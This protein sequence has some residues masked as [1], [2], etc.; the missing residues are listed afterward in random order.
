MHKKEKIFADRAVLMGRVAEDLRA[1]LAI[2]EAE[3]QAMAK[4]QER[5][6]ARKAAK[7]NPTE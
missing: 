2:I 7:A 6:A 5:F 1:I 3:A 4:A